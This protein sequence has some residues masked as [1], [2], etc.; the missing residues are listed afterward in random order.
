MSHAIETKLL[1]RNDVRTPLGRLTAAGFVNTNVGVRRR[2]MRVLGSYALVYLL[3]G[4]GHYQDASHQAH[5]LGPGDLLMIFPEIAHRYGPGVGEHWSEFYVVFDG[6]AFDLWREVGLLNPAQPLQHLEPIGG[7]LA[8]LEAAVGEP[9]ALTLAG[10]TQEISRFLQLLTEI[11]GP[12][13]ADLPA[14]TE[15]PWLARAC[16]LLEDELTRD[17]DLAGVAEEV[18]MSYETFRK[19]FQQ[20]VGVAPARYRAIRRIDAACAMLQDPDLTTHTIATGLGFSDE[21]HFSRRFKQITGL[22]PREF[23][24]RLPRGIDKTARPKLHGPPD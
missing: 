6:P 12:S 13:L 9:R 4:S 15:P 22:S 3:E 16:R 5:R 17:I 18:G 14:A 23:R 21:F 19:R 2:S 24:R 11:A 10:R 1:F 7:W 20:H 8:R